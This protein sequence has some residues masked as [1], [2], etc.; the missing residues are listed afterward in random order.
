MKTLTL[1]FTLTAFAASAQTILI[2]DNNPNRPTGPNIYAT[3]QAAVN[4]AA[5]NDIVYVQP[6]L[7]NYGPVIIDK[8]ITL[9]GIGYY[10]AQPL[11]SSVG[12]ITLTNR[13]DN[14][15]NASGTT[16]EGLNG[17]NTANTSI[18][19]GLLTGGGYTLQNIT[20]SR[21]GGF[22][23]NRSGGYVATDNITIQN[24]YVQIQ[25]LG[26][27]VSNLRVIRCFL[28]TNVYILNAPSINVIFS[29]N[30]VV[31][32]T[33]MHFS[34][35]TISG[36]IL[37]N[38][39]FL[40]GTNPTGSGMPRYTSGCCPPIMTDWLVTNNIF[41]GSSPK[42]SASFP[43]ERNTYTNNLSVGNADNTLPPV[44]TG[45][46]NTGSG[47]I[48][49][50]DPLF[51]NAPFNTAWAGNEDFR[52]QA[53]SPA[54]NAG[55]DGTDLGITGGAYPVTGGNVTLGLP[56]IPL[57]TTFNPVSILPQNQPLKA[58]IKAKAN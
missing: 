50:Q 7:T 55:F 2:A 33:Q 9:R 22:I 32:D 21:C 40:G 4:A 51:V 35:S 20:I 39:I 25:I 6:S 18:N 30:V 27:G 19:L 10:T 36:G 8:K 43:F 23:V 47:N 37:A 17:W 5:A 11:Y 28:Y 57:I 41:Y 56:S 42:P 1:L 26:A 52:L 48:V 46:G 12:N 53:A 49:G 34:N 54:K 31:Q 44:G 45:S 14:T 29:N 13:A 16:I 38:N 58:N 15:S 24:S 3:I